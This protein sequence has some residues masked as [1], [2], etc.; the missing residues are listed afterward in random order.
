MKCVDG[1]GIAPVIKQAH[2]RGIIA[3]EADK[4]RRLRRAIAPAFSERALSEQEVYLQAHSNNLIHHLRTRCIEGPVDMGKWLNLAT[5]D[6]I[7]GQ[8]RQMHVLSTILT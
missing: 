4:H 6:I 3:A 8:C 2:L 1:R 7:S 5:F